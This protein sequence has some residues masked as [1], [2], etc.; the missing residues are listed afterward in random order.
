MCSL[1]VSTFAKGYIRSIFINTITSRRKEI[2]YDSSTLLENRGAVLPLERD[3]RPR[4][5]Q[6][7]LAREVSRERSHGLPYQSHYGSL[8]KIALS[9]RFF[10]VACRLVSSLPCARTSPRIRTIGTYIAHSRR[11]RGV[12]RTLAPI[13]RSRIGFIIIGCG[14]DLGKFI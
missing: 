8:Q 3:A 1:H 12:G 13:N 6:K 11:V 2:I 14:S 5:R 9:L 4:T 10:G 7:L